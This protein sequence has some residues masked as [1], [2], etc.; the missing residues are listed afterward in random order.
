MQKNLCTVVVIALLALSASP[1]LCSDDLRAKT[2]ALLVQSQKGS[3]DLNTNRVP[4]HEDVSFLFSGMVGG[5]EKGTF[6]RDWLTKDQWRW[7]WELPGYQ[8]IN[9]R[10]GPQV[11]ERET[12]IFESIRIQQ[13]RWALPP[14]HALMGEN[15]L[16][17]K[18]EPEKVD[19]LEAQCI[20]FEAVRGRDKWDRKICLNAQDNTLLRWVDERR[21]IEWTD[22]TP[23]RESVYPRHL[24]VREHGNKIIQADI[25]FR[26]A[27][28]LSPKVFEIPSDMRSRK[29][30]EH[31]VQPIVTKR[32]DPVYPRRIGSRTI[33][34]DV[35]VEVR[36]GVDGKVEAAQITETA[37]SDLDQAA[38]DAVKKWEFE[39]GKCDGEP[40]TRNF[41]VAVYF[42]G[43]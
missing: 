16:V 33:K 38:L 42:G 2:N 39:P 34:A 18:I 43:R 3:F 37:G 8:E 22:Y 10:S 40:V 14:F 24:V 23:F 13:L 21:E 4:F 32:E 31:F 30:C 27:P 19:G 41:S 17:K 1:A 11:G 12:A 25:A 9:V 15:D 36:V 29:A 5:D 7:K 35:V 6:V 26:D 28:D 20:R